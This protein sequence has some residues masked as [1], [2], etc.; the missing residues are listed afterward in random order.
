MVLMHK[1]LPTNW[2]A[3]VVDVWQKFVESR[4]ME[5]LPYLLRSV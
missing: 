2:S 1:N 3:L 5:S 4:Q